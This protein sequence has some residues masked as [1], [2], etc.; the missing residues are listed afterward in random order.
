MANS[1]I[2]RWPQWLVGIVLVSWGLR[3]L[4]AWLLPPGF[5]EAYYFLYTQHWDWSYFD[6][7][8]MVALTT[9]VGPALTGYLSPLTLRL[10][11]LGLYGL[12]TVLLFLTGRWLFD[13]AAARYAVAIAAISPLFIFSF[14]LLT[15]P[16]NGLILFWTAAGYVAARE[17]FPRGKSYRS[18]PKLALLGLL[19]GLACLSKYHGFLLGLSLVGFCLTS[20]PH[21]RALISPWT[22]LSLVIF[23]ATLLPLIVWNAQNGWISF[24][25]HLSSRFEGDVALQARPLNILVTW[26]VGIAYLFPPLGFALWW[27]VWQRLRQPSAQ[28]Q[29]VLWTGLPTALGFTLLGGVSQIYP[30]WPAPGLWSLSLLLGQAMS[31]WPNRQRWLRASAG[32]IGLLLSVAL[33]HV[34][35]GT[36]QSA[37]R[38]TLLPAVSPQQ[39]PTT[40]L[41]DVVQLRR[42]LASMPTATALEAADVVVTSEFWLSGYV[43]MAISP[44]TE[45]PVM[46]LGE[47]PRGHALWFSPADW[48]GKQGVFITIADQDQIEIQQRYRPY[49][50]KFELL[51]TVQTF[52]GGAVTE[53]FYLYELGQITRAYVYPY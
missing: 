19:L 26:L 44:L 30:A 9:A 36:F 11:A 22:C 17:F 28:E 7:P 5:D 41:I 6:H 48:V 49:F 52:R 32:V 18:T 23:T 34:A 38:Y 47:D 42:A 40:T 24:G 12:S 35:L 3:L 27:V 15:A 16:D 13:A 39:D 20:R 45:I 1:T 43:D 53:T 37:G 14:G 25:F 29:L 4:I 46:T 31:R 2:N 50:E 8:V 51:D 33:S 10:G 21:R